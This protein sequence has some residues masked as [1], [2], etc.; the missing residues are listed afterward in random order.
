M[1]KVK[2]EKSCNNLKKKPYINQIQT[3]LKNTFTLHICHLYNYISF[4]FDSFFYFKPLLPT[5]VTD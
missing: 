3:Y 4:S 1:N 2:V 5:D